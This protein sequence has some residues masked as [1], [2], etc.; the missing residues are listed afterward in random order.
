MAVQ[1]R[2][3][4]GRRLLGG[5]SPGHGSDLD[6]APDQLLTGSASTGRLETA[7]RSHPAE[8]VWTLST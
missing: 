4:A 8:G 2:P 6:R 3:R 7:G 1:R 5:Q